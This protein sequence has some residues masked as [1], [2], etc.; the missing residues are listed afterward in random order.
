MLRLPRPAGRRTPGS[1][2]PPSR[3]SSGWPPCWPPCEQTRPRGPTSRAPGAY[4]ST[5]HS[6]AQRAALLTLPPDAWCGGLTLLLEMPEAEE[7]MPCAGF[8]AVSR[9][10]VQVPVNP[11]KTTA[12]TTAADGV[13]AFT[14][15][16]NV[17]WSHIVA[18]RHNGDVCC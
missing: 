10:S 17:C 2:P 3:S 15:G 8:A 9:H 6:P 7:R 12:R 4:F 1:G 11:D 14:V 18:T 16:R 5:R 13:T